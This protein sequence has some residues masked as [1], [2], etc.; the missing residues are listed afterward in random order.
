MNNAAKGLARRSKRD[1][2]QAADH[3]LRWRR[4]A[5]VNMLTFDDDRR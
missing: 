2:S 4:T 1:E 5:K 3:L